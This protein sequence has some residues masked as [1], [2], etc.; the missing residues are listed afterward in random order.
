[1]PLG[2]CMK[3]DKLCPIVRVGLHPLSR[4]A[5]WR[6]LVHDKVPRHKTCGAELEAVD[7]GDPRDPSTGWRCPTCAT[8]EAALV[9]DAEVDAGR[10]VDGHLTDI[11][12][13]SPR[14]GLRDG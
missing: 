9:P 2:I 4:E 1:M 10:C 14:K 13:T 6:P 8:P 3:C 12:S 7:C 5:V 11:R